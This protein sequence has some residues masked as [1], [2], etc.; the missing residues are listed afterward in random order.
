MRVVRCSQTPRP[1]Q[2]GV[3]LSTTR[4]SRRPAAGSDVDAVQTAAMARPSL[5][6]RTSSTCHPPN[7]LGGSPRTTT[8]G[9]IRPLPVRN[10]RVVMAY[11]SQ[12]AEASTSNDIVE[13][14]DQFSAC[15]SCGADVARGTR[16]LDRRSSGAVECCRT[17]TKKHNAL[18][19]ERRNCLFDVIFGASSTS[20]LKN[21][22]LDRCEWQS[23]HFDS[24]P[25]SRSQT[26]PGSGRSLQS[27]QMLSSK[28][29]NIGQKRSRGVARFL[30]LKPLR[31]LFVRNY[32]GRS[33]GS[34]TDLS[35]SDDQ[36]AS[37]TLATSVPCSAT[38]KSSSLSTAT[39]PA[40]SPLR[41]W[42]RRFRCRDAPRCRGNSG[43]V[44]TKTS[45]SSTC[46]TLTTVVMR[47]VTTGET[48]VTNVQKQR[49]QTIVTSGAVDA[50]GA[51]SFPDGHRQSTDVLRRLRP[52][53]TLNL[54]APS[55][56]TTA[57]GHFQVLHRCPMTF[58]ESPE[59]IGQCSIGALAATDAG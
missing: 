10:S 35:P 39:A 41:L 57:L 45:K 24:S 28:S 18:G 30:S 44:A 55:G 19:V 12:F 34:L 25:P 26:L 29:S 4:R 46:V 13:K 7:L 33:A 15:Q 48:E 49:E 51:E 16:C 14:F 43:V 31:R 11:E 56:L 53:T 42:L 47:D 32:G 38:S 2:S 1:L 8:P 3:G 58:L 22:T 50:W 37:K 17:E 23:S 9:C 59:S 54:A 52:P 27:F 36:Q 6:V 20:E 5:L 40:Q 21:N